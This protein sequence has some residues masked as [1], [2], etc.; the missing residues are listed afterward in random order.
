MYVWVRL[1][2][3]FVLVYACVIVR[4]GVCVCACLHVCVCV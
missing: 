1:G 3:Q 4:M 2:E